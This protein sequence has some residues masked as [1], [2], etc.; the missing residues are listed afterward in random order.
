M[1]TRYQK[2]KKAS[3]LGILGNFF[4]FVIK[5]IIGLFTKSSAMMADAFNSLSDILSSFMAFIGNLIASKPSDDDHNLGHGKAEYIYSL[6]I[7]FMMLFLSLKIAYDSIIALFYKSEFNFSYWL[8]IICLITILTKLALYLYNKYLAKTI[9]NVLLEASYKDHRNDIIIT[10]CNL[11][12]VLFSLKGIYFFD[13][14]VSLGIAIWILKEG[15]IIFKKSYDVLMDKSISQ[16]DKNKVIEIINSYPEIKKINHFNSTPI[17]YQYQI[18]FTIFVDGNLSTY[19]SHDIANKLEK[20]IVNKI[21]E[22]FLTVI[23]V[24]PID[25]NKNK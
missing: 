16:E 20:E 17:G 24:N 12:S 11:I 6:F 9:N 22:V 14:L 18:S 8:I 2:V 3:I 23:H 25:V 7:S 5:F 10:S 13:A 15:I 19:K 1:K 21:P 4:L